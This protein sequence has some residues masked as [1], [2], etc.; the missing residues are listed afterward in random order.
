MAGSV[1]KMEYYARV[2]LRIVH[3]DGHLD[4]WWLEPAPGDTYDDMFE[5]QDFNF[6]MQITG[7][8]IE[9]E[10]IGVIGHKAI[11]GWDR[12]WELTDDGKQM[13]SEHPGTIE[14]D[15]FDIAATRKR[16]MEV[17]GDDEDE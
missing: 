14:V 10:S 12:R 2:T 4:M 7:H 11:S 16:V 15:A 5:A 9:L 1:N 8:L 13:V 6:I 17:N 3:D